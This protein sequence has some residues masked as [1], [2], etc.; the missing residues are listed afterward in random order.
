MVIGSGRRGAK[1]AGRMA[2][3]SGPGVHG[4]GGSVV[5]DRRGFR[6]EGQALRWLEAL[7]PPAIAASDADSRAAVVSYVPVNDESSVAE[8]PSAEP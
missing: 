6:L 5:R 3:P 7:P 8:F 4:V 2:A 1:R